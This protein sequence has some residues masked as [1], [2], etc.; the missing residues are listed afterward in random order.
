M[1]NLA[2]LSADKHSLWVTEGGVSFQTMIGKLPGI[3]F[4][5][6]RLH[7]MAGRYV[8]PQSIGSSNRVGKGL[9]FWPARL[10]RLADRYD[11]DNSVPTRFL[12]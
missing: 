3:S 6:K 12:A 10:H 1:N 7:K 9:S 11:Y 4:Q 5:Q 8:N 2:E